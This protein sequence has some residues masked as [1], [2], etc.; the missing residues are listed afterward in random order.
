MY[1]K[2]GPNVSVGANVVIGKGARILNS[3]ILDGAEIKVTKPKRVVKVVMA[4]NFTF[5]AA[6]M[7]YV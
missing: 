3:V 5:L 4:T 6:C 7:Y 1:S 2:I